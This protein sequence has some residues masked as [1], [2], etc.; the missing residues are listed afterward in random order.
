MPVS[1]VAS[2]YVLVNLSYIMKRFLIF[3]GENYYPRGGW[4]DYAGQAD[5]L[6]EALLKVS[7]RRNV[8]DWFHIFDTEANE[9]VESSS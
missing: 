9:I 5:T 6:E 4:R 3:A 7:H 1:R 2:F 8:W